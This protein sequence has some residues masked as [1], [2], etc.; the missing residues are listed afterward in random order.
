MQI[1]RRILIDI[2]ALCPNSFSRSHADM[3]VWHPDIA[4]FG[5]LVP[6]VENVVTR[7]HAV[8]FAQAKTLSDTGYR[9]KANALLRL[10]SLVLD[11]DFNHSIGPWSQASDKDEY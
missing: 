11:F 2:V 9:S 4:I 5:L 1:M 6:N 3:Q 10:V 7:P 8:G